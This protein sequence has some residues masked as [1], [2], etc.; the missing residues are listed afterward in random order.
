MVVTNDVQLAGVVSRVNFRLVGA[1][2]NPLLTFTLEMPY[3]EG[4]E[5]QYTGT[6]RC[7]VK[8]W[9]AL[10]EEYANLME[11]WNVQVE[12]PIDVRRYKSAVRDRGQVVTDAQGN[13]VETWFNDAAITARN[14]YLL[15]DVTTE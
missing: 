6:R 14:L 12:G 2:Q 15:S 1:N 3:E 10:A 11:G 7:S 9:G 5:G 8:V 4:N 13:P